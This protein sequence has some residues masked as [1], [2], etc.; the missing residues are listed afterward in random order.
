M[1]L[2][3]A[4]PCAGARLLELGGGIEGISYWKAVTRR[5][6]GPG[7]GRVFQGGRGKDAWIWRG[8]CPG[9]GYR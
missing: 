4:F 9:V 3:G 2:K 1:P 5:V 7:R 6:N 8:R